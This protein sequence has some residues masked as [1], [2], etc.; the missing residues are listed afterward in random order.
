[1]TNEVFFSFHP[2]LYNL[3]KDRNVHNEVRNICKV[4]NFRTFLKFLFAGGGD[5]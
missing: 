3:N 2:Y 4:R 1:M 5:T